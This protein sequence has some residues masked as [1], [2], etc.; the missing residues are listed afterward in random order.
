MGGKDVH[1]RDCNTDSRV[2]DG[3]DNNGELPRLRAHDRDSYEIPVTYEQ[4]IIPVPIPNSFSPETQ[5]CQ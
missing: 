3:N 1:N 2:C 4:L 5:D